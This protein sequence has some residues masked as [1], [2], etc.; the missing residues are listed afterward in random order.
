[1]H[2]VGTEH[3]PDIHEHPEYYAHPGEGYEESL[4]AI[5]KARDNPEAPIRVYRGARSSV[6]EINHG[7]WVTPSKKYALQHGMHATDPKKDWPVISRVVKAK[8]L[9]T[10]GDDVNEWGYYPEQTG[11][12]PKT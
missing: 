1:M 3:F 7:D 12:D 4:R 5:M 6:T 2:A 9:R 8:D 10:P 11:P